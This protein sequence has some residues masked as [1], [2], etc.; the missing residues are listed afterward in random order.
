M[1][2]VYG[3]VRV[4]SIDQNEDRQMPVMRKMCYKPIFICE[5]IVYDLFGKG[6]Q[7]AYISIGKRGK[8]RNSSNYIVIER[9]V[10]YHI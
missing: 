4:S 8:V 3:Y 10:C 1:G 5:S 7:I 2:M 9:K 6:Q